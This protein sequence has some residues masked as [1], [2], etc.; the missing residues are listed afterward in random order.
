[1]I[2]NNQSKLSENQSTVHQSG[3][4]RVIFHFPQLMLLRVSCTCVTGKTRVHHS[5]Q[6]CDHT[7]VSVYMSLHMHPVLQKLARVTLIESIQQDGKKHKN[8]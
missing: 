7:F 8:K 5:S 1:M 4:K 6:T 3:N 2:N